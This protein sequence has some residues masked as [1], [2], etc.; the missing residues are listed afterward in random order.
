[1]SLHPTNELVAVAWL[2]G[3]TGLGDR[4]ATELPSDNTSWAASGFVQVTAIGGTPEATMPVARPAIS[5]DCWAVNA[6]T[7]RPPWGRA[8]QLA[9]YVRAAVHDHT[10]TPRAVTM[11]AAYAG[12]RVLTAYMLNEPRRI[13]TDPADYARFNFDL[14]LSW[15]EL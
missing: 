9:E 15:I 3:V 2:K 10:A 1:M 4:V 8:N 5:V 6:D 12:A 13:R 11:P 14:H 7:G